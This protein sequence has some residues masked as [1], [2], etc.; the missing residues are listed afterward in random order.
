MPRRKSLRL[1]GFDYSSPRSYFVTICTYQR[2]LLFGS[3]QGDR[4]DYSKAGKVV[5]LVWRSL[6]SRLVQISLGCLQTMPN[7]F[8]AILRIRDF[9]EFPRLTLGEVVGAF[10]SKVM[11]QYCE[12]VRTADWPAYY[13]SLWQRGYYDRIIRNDNEYEQ[14]S[15][16]IHS[17]PMRWQLDRLNP[18]NTG[19]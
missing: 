14:L 12:G 11:S 17:N 8:H 9:P 6:P 3:I 1:H 4:M 19:R 2:R 10:K 18:E 7:H 15:E 13:R 16:Y 5:N